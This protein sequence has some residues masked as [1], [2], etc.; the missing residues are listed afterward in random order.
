MDTSG[1]WTQIPFH[2]LYPDDIWSEG[3]NRRGNPMR[4]TPPEG[5][6]TRNPDFCV[7]DNVGTWWLTWKGQLYRAIPGLCVAQFGPDEI[8][9]F[10]AHPLLT[11]VFVDKNGNAL[12]RASSDIDPFLMLRPKEPPPQTAVTFERTEPDSYIAHLD[13]RTRGAVTFRWQLDGGEWQ[14]GADRNLPLD[15]LPNGLHTLCVMAMAEGLNIQ[16]QP[17][18]ATFS[19]K[20]DVARQIAALI[21]QLG[22][23]NYDRRKAAVAALALQPGRAIPALER[24]RASSSSEDNSWW[25]DVALQEARSTVPSTP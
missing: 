17:T 3:G 23:P 4:Q 11:K 5:A 19:T 2:S 10:L 6:V 1:K 9:P 21:A 18:V 25:I 8:N 13:P 22:D 24:A 12:F 15:H 16:A 20:I 14:Q 7:K